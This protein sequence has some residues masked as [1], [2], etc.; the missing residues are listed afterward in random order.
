MKLK[1]QQLASSLQKGLAPIYLIS[2]DESLLVQESCDLIRAQCRQQGFSEREVFH[3]EGQFKWDDVLLSANSLSLFADKKLIEIRFRNAKLGKDGSEAITQ[4]LQSPSP[5]AILL[6]VLPK[7][8]GASTRSK[9][10]KSVEKEGVTVPIWPIERSA[11]PRWIQQR[12]QEQNLKA[13]DEAVEFLADNVEGNLLAA[14]QEIEKLRLL[15][16]DNVI[17]LTM[18]MS[19]I[20]NSSRYTV[21]NLVDKCLSGNPQAAMRT[22]QG[23]KSEGIETTLILWSLTREIRTLHRIQFAQQQGLPLG[24]VM[25]NE[26]VFESRQRLF[27]QALSRLPL[28]KLE[29]LLRRARSIDQSI[30]GIKS[31]SPWM[32]LEQLTLHMCH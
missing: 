12:L 16:N 24:Q 8:D 20:S 3:V 31:E 10:Y 22:L 9:W 17:D 2:G 7:L 1:S 18:M 13:S 23:L 26:R 6:L 30:K 27:Q 19:L 28:R 11:L 21:F 32:Q 5:D 25:R 29:T 14:K 4:Y 15:T